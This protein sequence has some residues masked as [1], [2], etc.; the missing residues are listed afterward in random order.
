MLCRCS[1]TVLNRV[2]FDVPPRVLKTAPKKPLKLD[3]STL[4]IFKALYWC[5]Q[6]AFSNCFLVLEMAPFGRT[7]PAALATAAAPRASHKKPVAMSKP[8][9]PR[10]A[11]SHAG[12]RARRAR[13]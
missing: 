2:S 5:S 9:P 10:Y 7:T 8:K 13:V 1:L 3:K 12:A 6:G 4:F 11:P